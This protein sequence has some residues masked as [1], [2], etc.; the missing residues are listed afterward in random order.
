MD[1]VVWASFFERV[2][3]PEVERVRG[4]MGDPS[5]M[6]LIIVD[7][8]SS[9]LN[10]ELWTEC[11]SKNIDVLL[12]PAHTSHILQPL[13]LGVNGEFKREL[14]GAPP[15]PKKTKL[16]AELE[17]FLTTLRQAIHVALAPHTIIHGFHE[18]GIVCGSR[19]EAL[20]KCITVLPPN[21]PEAKVTT[22]FSISGELV[23]DPDFLKQWEEIEKIKAKKGGGE[24]PRERTASQPEKMTDTPSQTSSASI[25][26]STSI[27][28]LETE[29]GEEQ[30]LLLRTTD[31]EK[32]VVP[33]CGNVKI[34]STGEETDS[35]L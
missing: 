25:T 6:A 26:A 32:P 15:F 7:G 18:A 11:S 13:D 33:I 20:K 23:T 16:L 10:R 35:N 9:R 34:N 22:R 4:V 3:F 21:M 19:T 14:E 28:P 12:L 27:D 1:K 29:E 5:K 24:K 30:V 8:H 31:D 2:I 17:G